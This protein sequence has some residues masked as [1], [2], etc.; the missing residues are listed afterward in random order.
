MAKVSK[1]VVDKELRKQTFGFLFN[2]GNSENDAQ[3]AYYFHKINDRQYG[4][5][6]KDLNGTERYVRLAAIVAEERDDMTARE[7]MESEIATYEQKQADKEEKA[8]KKESK[9]AK[10]KA[11]RAEA[12]EVKE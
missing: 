9:I 5:L 8:K 3:T 7:L 2:T 6:L 11:A 12:K 4:I 1:T 10:D